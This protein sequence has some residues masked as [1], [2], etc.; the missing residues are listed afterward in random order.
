[1]Q[2][3]WSHSAAELQQQRYCVGRGWHGS[4]GLQE[5]A[6]RVH[7][8]DITVGLRAVGAQMSVNLYRAE[9]ALQASKSL[10]AATVM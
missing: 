9:R 7:Q 2:R 5:V 6:P 4:V 3:P 8:F 10:A 1:M